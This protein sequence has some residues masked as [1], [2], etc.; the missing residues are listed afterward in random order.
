MPQ[1][2][3]RFRTVL[4]H[5]NLAMLVGTHGAGI[6]IDIRV[7]LLCGDFQASGFQ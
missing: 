2:Q 7:Q 5:I 1:I 4:G 3:I 6:Y